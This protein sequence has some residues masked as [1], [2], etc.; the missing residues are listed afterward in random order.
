MQFSCDVLFYCEFESCSCEVYYIQH[1][2]TKIVSDLRQVV[3]FLWTLKFPYITW[4]SLSGR[5]FSLDTQ[6]SSAN[7]NDRHDITE[8]L[9]NVVLQTITINSFFYFVFVNALEV[10]RNSHGSIFCGCC[11]TKLILLKSDRPR[12]VVMSRLIRDQLME[13]LLAKS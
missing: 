7:K 11:L 1:Y 12:L 4:Q 8:I 2:V 3:D 9:L 13:T 5:R 10:K 6:V